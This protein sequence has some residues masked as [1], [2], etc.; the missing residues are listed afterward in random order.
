MSTQWHPL[1]AHLLGLLIADYYE[2]QTEVPVSDLP[3]KGDL[4]LIRRQKAGPPLPSS[5]CGAT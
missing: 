3:R 1:F 5:G 4:L 2:I